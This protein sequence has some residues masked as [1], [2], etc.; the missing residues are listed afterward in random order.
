VRAGRAEMSAPSG[1]GKRAL[2]VFGIMLTQS[3][4]SYQCNT[5]SIEVDAAYKVEIH[6]LI[7]LCAGWK[8]FIAPQRYLHW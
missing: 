4:D 2:V 1:V 3:G 7:A 6:P 5:E 8:D